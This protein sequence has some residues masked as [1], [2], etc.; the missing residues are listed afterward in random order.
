MEPIEEAL[1]D[2]C[3]QRFRCAS[4][5]PQVSPEPNANTRIRSPGRNL[6]AALVSESRI[7]M[8][9]AVVFPTRWMFDKSFSPGSRSTDA[10]VSQMR[11]FAWCGRT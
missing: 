5:A 11:R 2:W 9:A 10:N 4:D 7:G 1:R 6:P 3:A 8:E